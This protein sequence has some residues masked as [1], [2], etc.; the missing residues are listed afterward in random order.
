MKLPTTD[1]IIRDFCIGHFLS[2]MLETPQQTFDVLENCAE[3]GLAFPDDITP[4]QP[5]EYHSAN[6]LWEE[7]ENLAQQIQGYI[8]SLQEE[9]NKKQKGFC[10]S[11]EN[12]REDSGEVIIISGVCDRDAH[13]TQ[14]PGF[15]PV[16]YSELGEEYELTYTQ[17]GQD[18]QERE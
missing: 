7:M 13:V 1:E 12:I 18:A 9:K 6:Q 3:K 11:K 8:K 15:G 4:W 16:T 5:F 14:P 17:P 10:C 2:E